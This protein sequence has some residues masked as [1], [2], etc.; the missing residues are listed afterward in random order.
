[1][2]CT[3]LT[4]GAKIDD[5]DMSGKVTVLSKKEIVAFEQFISACILVSSRAPSKKPLY[6]LRTT[7]TSMS[8]ERP[9]TVIFTVVV[10]K[11]SGALPSA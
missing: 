2:F 9:L 7:M 11:T 5:D 10:P 8:V 1:M 3:A 6:K 4:V